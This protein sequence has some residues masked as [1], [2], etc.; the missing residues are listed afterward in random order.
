MKRSYF[1]LGYR[2]LTRRKSRTLLTLLGVV[3]AIGFTVGLLSISEGFMSSFDRIMGATGP[4][5]FIVPKGQGNIPFPMSMGCSGGALEERTASVVSGIKGVYTAEPLIRMFASKK[6][7]AGMLGDMPMMTFAVP[8][9]T[10]FRLRPRATIAKGRALRKSDKNAH[11]AGAVLA[12]NLELEPGDTLSVGGVPFTVVGILA[13]GDDTYDYFGYIPLAA[14]QE[15]RELPDKAC[16][17]MVKLDKPTDAGRVAR[18][19]TALYPNVD[20]QSMEEIGKHFK[21][22]M[23]MSQAVHFAV[24]CFALLIGVLFVATTM[25][26]SVS[27]RVREFATIRVIGASR[28]Y[29]L[30][31]IMSEALLLSFLGGLGGLVLGY[32]LSKGIDYANYVYFRESFVKTF[33]SLKI[34]GVAMGVSLLIGTFA[35]ILP[36]LTI[37]R[38]PMAENL[39]YE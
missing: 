13:R 16:G 15:I 1:T 6:N 32:A 2:N 22:M 26:M 23:M 9:E 28:G 4:E 25:I 29:I 33:I 18:R 20:I 3:L 17:I 14:A 10:F 37:L 39:R 11:L 36:A 35:G 5:L 24:S 12:K 8:P 27:E 31:M 21:R 19:I 7:A 38:K 30:R 34:I